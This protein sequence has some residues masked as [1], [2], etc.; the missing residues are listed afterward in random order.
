[1]YFTYSPRYFVNPLSLSQTHPALYSKVKDLSNFW[2]LIPLL[3]TIFVH[4]EDQLTAMDTVASSIE[5]FLV[6]SVGAY[7]R[8]TAHNMIEHKVSPCTTQVTS[9]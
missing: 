2:E 4:I 5:R 3:Q 9:N 8:M 7:I 6:E 1:M